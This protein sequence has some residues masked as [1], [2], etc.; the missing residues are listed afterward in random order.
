LPWDGSKGGVLVFN[1]ANALS[2]G[3]N[4]NVSGKGFIGGQGRNT[5]LLVTN[6]YTNN[7]SYP[8]PGG[9]TIAAE[10]GEGISFLPNS[11]LLGK[12]AAAN[13]GGGGLDHNSGGGG[14]GNAG[15]GGFGGCQLAACGVAPYPQ[16]DNRGNRWHKSSL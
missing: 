1:V 11:I 4:I 15:V 2:L 3:A 12:G 5:G 16:F 7:F 6:C 9:M 13:A 10:K 8:A 14:G